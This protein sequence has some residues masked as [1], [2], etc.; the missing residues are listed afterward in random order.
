M[1]NSIINT[2]NS[3]DNNMITTTLRFRKMKVQL[4]MAFEGANF[5]SRT[6]GTFIDT[7]GLN[8]SDLF[9][10]FHAGMPGNFSQLKSAMFIINN[11]I[12]KCVKKFASS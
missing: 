7:L 5:Y 3:N 8:A 12:S 2:E 6:H 11:S 4:E 9:A 10:E 1:N